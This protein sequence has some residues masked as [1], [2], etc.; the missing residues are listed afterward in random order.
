M[1]LR[2]VWQAERYSWWMTSLLHRF[3]THSPF[4]QRMQQAE[5]DELTT[6]HAAMTRLAEGY[7]GLP[8]V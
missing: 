7:V 1:A 5:L 8:L 6:S 3:D 4:E 2:R